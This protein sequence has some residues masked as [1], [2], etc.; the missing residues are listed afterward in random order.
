MRIF[1][2]QRHAG[3]AALPGATGKCESA[4]RVLCINYAAKTEIQ[5]YSMIE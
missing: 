4:V 3:R 1:S 5:Y 2:K